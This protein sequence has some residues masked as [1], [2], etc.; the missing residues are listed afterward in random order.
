VFE[1]RVKKISKVKLKNVLKDLILIPIEVIGELLKND[2]SI[3]IQIR[4]TLD[5]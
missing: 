5:G 1:Q 4:Q 3:Y 2:G